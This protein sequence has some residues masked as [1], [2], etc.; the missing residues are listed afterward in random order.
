MADSLLRELPKSVTHKAVRPVPDFLMIQIKKMKHATKM[1]GIS[2][3][4]FWVWLNGIIPFT[5]LCKK[6]HCVW[7]G[8]S[9]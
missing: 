9:R 5:N 8:L 6:L 1:S 2:D 7:C 3:L 4:R